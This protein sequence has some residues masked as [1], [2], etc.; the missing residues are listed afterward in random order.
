MYTQSSTWL[1]EC[2][3]GRGEPETG[4]PSKPCPPR[5]SPSFLFDRRFGDGEEPLKRKQ[6]LD[7]LPL[8]HLLN[9]MMRRRGRNPTRAVFMW[10]SY[11]L[12]T[13]PSSYMSQLPPEAFTLPVSESVSKFGI[14][15][16]MHA[17]THST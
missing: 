5:F 11:P 8:I 1:C 4:A 14:Q 3:G 7:R 9:V 17:F 12:I 13:N 6:E 2:T 10:P 16:D 15:R